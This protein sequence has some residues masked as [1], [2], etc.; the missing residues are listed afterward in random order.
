[1]SPI[2][3]V[4]KVMS[5]DNDKL[6]ESHEDRISRLEEAMGQMHVTLLP[7]LASLDSKLDNVS[8]SLLEFRTEV[9]SDIRD[10]RGGLEEVKVS[11]AARDGSIAAL[12]AVNEKRRQRWSALFKWVTPIIAAVA[13]AALLVLLGLK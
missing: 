10:L 9:K 2:K 13:T 8:T 6:L 3:P 4:L 7:S 12:E 5:G 11:A 1:M